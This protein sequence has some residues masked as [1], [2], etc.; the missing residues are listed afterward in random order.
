[1]RETI[2]A[3]EE[4]RLGGRSYLLPSFEEYKCWHSFD[5]ILLFIVFNTTYFILQS[6]SINIA[7]L[8]I[9]TVRASSTSTFTKM[10]SLFSE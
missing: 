4:T 9:A 5:V 6:D 10:T 3:I 2:S 7:T 8:T 1:M